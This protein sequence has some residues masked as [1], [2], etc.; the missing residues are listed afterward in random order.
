MHS[1]VYRDLVGL[2]PISTAN[3]LDMKQ[4]IYLKNG[5][6]FANEFLSFK[7]PEKLDF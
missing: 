5:L 7:D 1:T 2:I 6:L 3:D 4:D